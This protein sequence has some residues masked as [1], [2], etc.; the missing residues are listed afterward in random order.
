MTQEFTQQLLEVIAKT[1]HKPVENFRLEASFEELGLDSL[2]G[3]NILFA[4]EN[5]FGIQIPDEAAR[6]VKSLG[7]M[8]EGVWKLVEAKGAPA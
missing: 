4:L 1:V 5:E 7:E 6:N 8:A 2:D 3:I